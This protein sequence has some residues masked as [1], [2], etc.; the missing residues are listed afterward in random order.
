[1]R[2]LAETAELSVCPE[3][4]VVTLFPCAHCSKPF[5][6]TNK[7]QRFCSGKCRVDAFREPQ[8]AKHR[9]WDAARNFY[10]TMAFD[11]RVTG[12]KRNVGP[13]AQFEQPGA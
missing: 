10:R 9:R 4:E 2:H 13:L 7:R 6:P 8:R 3:A 5:T 1:M 11:G 12:S